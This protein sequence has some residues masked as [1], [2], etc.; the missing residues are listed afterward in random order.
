MPLQFPS[1]PSVNDAYSFNGKT[2]IWNGDGW[3]LATSGA[4][5]GIIIGNA[6]AAAG[7]FTMLT[8]ANVHV[9]DR[10]IVYL[11][12]TDSSNYTGFRAPGTLASNYVYVLPSN[13]GNNTQVL[14]TN[15]AGGLSWADAGSGGGQGATSYPNSTVQPV[16]GATGN[17]DLSYNFAQTEQEVPFEAA[18]T[19]AFGV[20]LGEVYSMMDPTGE[21][22]EPVDLG[23]LT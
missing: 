10:G 4:I 21:V 5:N 2:W 1:N 11:Y 8:G 18:G 7:T 12:D 19:D 3:A 13:Y 22:L 20:N 16:P 6:S 15:G 14:T 23:V 17:F 9:R